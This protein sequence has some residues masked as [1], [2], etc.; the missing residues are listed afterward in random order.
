LLCAL[1]IF[2]LLLGGCNTPRVE[3]VNIDDISISPRHNWNFSEDF[4][5]KVRYVQK[6]L[7]EVDNT[8]Y[9]QWMDEFDRDTHPD[10]ELYLWLYMTE[11]YKRMIV[12]YPYPPEVYRVIIGASVGATFDE[13]S[14]ENFEHLNSTAIRDIIDDLYK[15]EPSK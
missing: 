13:L 9:E 2:V 3:K 15:Y 4:K 11:V 14:Q 1:L 7:K 12:K 10:V 5:A 6:E 8:S